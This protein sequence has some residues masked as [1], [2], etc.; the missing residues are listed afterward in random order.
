MQEF[1]EVEGLDRSTKNPTL[2]LFQSYDPDI[3]YRTDY[4]TWTKKANPQIAN[5][6]KTQVPL[7]IKSQKEDIKGRRTVIKTI[8][9]GFNNI[10][11]TSGGHP[12]LLRLSISVGGYIAGGYLTESEAIELMDYLIQNHHYLCKGV[13]GYQKTMRDGIYL[14]QQNPIV[15]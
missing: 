1:E 7:I 6:P 12:S 15:L 9:T 8:N 4:T 3:F 10:S 5:F 11:K 2:S 14:G 13:S